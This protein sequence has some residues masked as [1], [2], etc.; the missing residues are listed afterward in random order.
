MAVPMVAHQETYQEA[1]TPPRALPSQPVPTH[2]QPTVGVGGETLSYLRLFHEIFLRQCLLPKT[3][4]IEQ[5]LTTPV[6]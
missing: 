2:L 4:P 6:T 5:L 1:P 3:I